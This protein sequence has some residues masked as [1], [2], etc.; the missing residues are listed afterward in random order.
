MA[1]HAESFACEPLESIA[2]HGAFRDSSRNGQT[3]ARDSAAAGPGEDGEE[4]ISGSGGICE[5]ATEFGRGVQALL[6]CEPFPARRQCGAKSQPVT[7]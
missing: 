6:G 4:A 2:V 3:E 7:A 1:L 5:H